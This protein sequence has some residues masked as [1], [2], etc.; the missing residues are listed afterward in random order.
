M[1]ILGLAI[2]CI[3]HACD[4]LHA[5]VAYVKVLFSKVLK[6]FSIFFVFVGFRPFSALFYHFLKL[7][8]LLP[9]T[10]VFRIIVLYTTSAA[11]LRSHSN[12]VH[13]I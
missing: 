2:S 1:H 3:F 8:E 10:C 7:L 12:K 11:F 13:L 6:H 5:I 9:I 4:F